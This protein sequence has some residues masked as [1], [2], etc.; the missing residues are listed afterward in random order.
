VIFHGRFETF[1]GAGLNRVPATPIPIWM[2]GSDDRV[3]RRAAALADG[4]I[5]LG[6]PAVFF[7]KVQAY[8]RDA[9]R[10]QSSFGFTGR[11]VAGPGGPSAWVEAAQQLQ[12]LG[13]THIS[14]SAPPDLQGDS[15]LGRLLEA[16]HALEA[17]LGS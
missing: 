4:F 9:G 1:D 13:A 5:P 10:D 2:G 15:A 7:P 17:E 16:R 6:D 3:L 14:I 12:A 11:L 8:L